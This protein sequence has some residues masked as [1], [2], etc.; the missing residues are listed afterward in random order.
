LTVTTAAVPAQQV[1][2]VHSSAAVH[3][4]PGYHGHLDPTDSQEVTGVKKLVMALLWMTTGSLSLPTICGAQS[5][6]KAGAF[7][8]A[9]AGTWL[10]NWGLVTLVAT[11]VANGVQISGSLQ[12]DAGQK[13]T[14]EN[15]TF[16][17][18]RR[19]LR[20]SYVQHWNGARGTATLT[21][22]SDGRHLTGRWTQP[23]GSGPYSMQLLFRGPPP[24]A[25]AARHHGL[26]VSNKPRISVL[27]VLFIPR[28]AKWI[29]Q[30]DIDTYAFLIYAHL[31][32][33][34]RH[35]KSLLVTDTFK[36]ADEPILVY[37]AKH[38]NEHYLNAMRKEHRGPGV[39]QLI[40][41]ELLDASHENRYT[42][43]RIYLTIYVRDRP[44]VAPQP[45][46]GGGR[47]FN[48][49]PNTGGGSVELE[50]A[51]LL[52]DELYHFQSALNHELGHA[53][54]LVHV[55]AHGYDQ[56]LNESNISYNPKITSRGLN[57]VTGGRFNPEE[58]L[59]LSLNRQA[60][61]DFRFVPAAHN[62]GGK[63][64]KQKFLACMTD[65]IGQRRNLPP[66][67]CMSYP[68]PCK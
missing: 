9:V 32:L 59:A 37:R 51:S 29:T 36:I 22:S 44:R 20:F 34:Q 46:H 50:L 64:L 53:L 16:D 3:P 21:L 31:E 12:Q 43:R 8:H 5:P 38:P 26:A 58:Y 24:R 30:S 14:I 28:D 13:G 48:G 52:R 4:C 42:S 49:P 56:R 10:S 2:L 7:A 39:A 62:P 45:W 17:P 18:G 6:P 47:T 25:G 55:D 33:A 27:P 1:R 68:C 54:G 57:P 15:G 67:S 60:F 63:P 65:H 35:Y 19:E 61:P 11:P 23:Q 41:R 66:Q 40:A